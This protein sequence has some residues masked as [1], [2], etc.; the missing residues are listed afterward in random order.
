MPHG[1]PP[2]HPLRMKRS[3]ME[4]GEEAVVWK[5]EE[6]QRETTRIGKRK[7]RLS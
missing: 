4:L 5:R 7:Y 2:M 1:L 3:G 6:P